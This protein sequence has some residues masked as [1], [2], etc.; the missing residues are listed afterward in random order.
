MNW[1]GEG[2][3]KFLLAQKIG[4][5]GIIGFHVGSNFPQLQFSV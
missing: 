5:F 3:S 2:H 4:N 1:E